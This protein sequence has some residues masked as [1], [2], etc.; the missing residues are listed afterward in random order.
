L[1]DG[2]PT[3]QSRRIE[4]HLQVHH[5]VGDVGHHLPEEIVVGALLASGDIR[6]PGSD[7]MD[8]LLKVSQLVVKSRPKAEA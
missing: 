8:N 5:A 1:D 2:K 3:Q 7:R 6:I 4:M